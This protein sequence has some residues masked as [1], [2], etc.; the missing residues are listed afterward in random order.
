MY[1]NWYARLHNEKTW[2]DEQGTVHII[3]RMS[4]RYA[5]NLLVWIERQHEGIVQAAANALRDVPLPPFDTHAYD[6]V[7]RSC[8]DEAAAMTNNPLAWLAETPLV[9]ALTEAATPHI[10]RHRNRKPH[11]RTVPLTTDRHLHSV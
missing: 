11:L 8:E 2:T 4:P 5:R 6:D 3:A 9:Q 7:V 10:A 1:A